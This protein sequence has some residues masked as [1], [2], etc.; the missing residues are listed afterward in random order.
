MSQA[1]QNMCAGM[2]KVGRQYTDI[3]HLSSLELKCPSPLCCC[4]SLLD[5]GSFGYG[6]EGSQASV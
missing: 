1:Y 5:D 6:R 4:V 3:L 2:Y